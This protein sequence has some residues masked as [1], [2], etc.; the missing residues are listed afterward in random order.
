MNKML[1]Q[2]AILAAMGM[3]LPAWAQTVTIGALVSAQVDSVQVKQGDTVKQGDVLMVLDK[4]T[5][6]ARLS[7]A[8]AKLD[9]QQVVFKFDEN[10]YLEAQDLFE[11]GVT[12]QRELDEEKLSYEKS[13]AQ[14]NQAKARVALI[15]AKQRYYVITAPQSG[16]VERVSVLPGTTVF[17]ENQSLIELKVD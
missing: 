11:Q 14:L 6:D 7:A 8:Q 4:A 1:K 9:Y 15:Q 17:K 13:L 3:A 2:A 16:V 5:Y 12:S 10:A